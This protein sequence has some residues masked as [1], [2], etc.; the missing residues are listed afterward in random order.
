M[1]P[2]MFCPRKFQL[3]G[4]SDDIT[5][6]IIFSSGHAHKECKQEEYVT[7]SFDNG[8]AY[9]YYRLKVL[10]VQ[11]EGHYRGIVLRDLKLFGTPLKG[12]EFMIN[13]LQ[14]SQ[15]APL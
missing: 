5:Y 10:D 14:G 7:W 15:A 2:R 3:E 6:E 12:T 1:T 11:G 9:K 13:A 4:S 8:Q